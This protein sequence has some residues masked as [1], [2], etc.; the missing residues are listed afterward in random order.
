MSL[1]LLLTEHEIS[2][3]VQ[4]RP[5]PSLAHPA[6]D[7][8]SVESFFRVAIQE[9]CTATGAAERTEW[10]HYGSGYASF[11]DSWFYYTDGRARRSVAD[12]HH[13]GVFVLFSRLT[14]TYALGQGE[15]AWS[16]KGGSS[17]LPN[18]D[19]IDVFDHPALTEMTS[20]I[21][22]TLKRRGLR[23]LRSAD[24]EPMISGI[25]HVPTILAN[26]PHRVFDAIFYWED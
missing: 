13:A 3:L 20:I 15:K 26:P 22:V 8:P 14:G 4:G 12:E 9:I 24:L 16:V 25:H 19:S 5:I 23:R 1:T 21:D 18:F 2:E 10:N 11:L 17:Y 7:Q 6:G